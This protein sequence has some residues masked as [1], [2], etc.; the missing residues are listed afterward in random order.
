VSKKLRALMNLFALKA[1]AAGVPSTREPLE[2][3]DAALRI[4]AAREALQIVA[5]RLIQALAHG[6]RFFSGPFH[7]LLVD[8]QC[9]I[10]EHSISEHVLRV[11]RGRPLDPF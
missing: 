9:N 8:R 7:D 2:L 11:N 3:L 10:H 4:I 1:P 5:D 6:F